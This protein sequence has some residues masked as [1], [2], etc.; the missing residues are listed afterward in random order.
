MI[1][2]L[3]CEDNNTTF[4]KKNYLLRA[5]ERSGGL[6]DTFRDYKLWH[7]DAELRFVLN[8]VPYSKFVVGTQWTGVWELDQI[9]DRQDA[10]ANWNYAD[11]IFLTAL[12]LPDRLKNF[13]SSRH[14]LLFQ[15]CDPVL[16]ERHGVGV[17][18]FVQ[19]GT[20]GDGIYS[21]RSRLISLL[22]KKYTFWDFGKNYAPLEYV[23]NISK[24]KV[25]FIRSTHNTFA[26]GEIAQRFFE[27]LAMGPVLTNWVEDL[28]HTGLIEGEDYMAYR[29][30]KELI[31]KMDLL[32]GDEALRNKIAKNGRNKALMYHSYEQ[33][34]MAIMLMALQDRR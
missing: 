8:I 6:G 16:H 26:T 9:C 29:N 23:K 22:N 25:Q 32:V 34:L 3:N 30:D 11:T 33:R 15:A 24:A 21:E 2:Y 4:N 18:D 1:V 31:E 7:P 5:A 14:R 19:C 13:F 17:Y 28:N 12:G 10:G 20:A 27:C